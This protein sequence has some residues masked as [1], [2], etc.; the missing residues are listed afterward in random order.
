[1][2]KEKFILVS[3]K[4]EESKKIAQI[5]TNDTSRKILDFLSEKEATESDLSKELKI[6][7]STIHYN[8]KALLKARMIEAEEFHYSKKGKEILHYKLANKYIIISPK[9]IKG[10]KNKLRSILPASILAFISSGI[11]FTINMLKKPASFVKQ[12]PVMAA[13]SL[14]KPETIEAANEITSKSTEEAALFMNDAVAGKAADLAASTP[15]IAETIIQPSLLEQ[16]IQNPASWFLLGCL[17]TL[18][19]ILV[20]E[21]ILSR[22]KT[23]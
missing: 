4:E 9:P 3:L 22:K 2:A 19:L 20:I 18:L 11:L 21:Y 8:L 6:P 16:F 15:Q 23:K 7:I 14:S 13:R 5:I 10:I 12:A 17:F 1:M